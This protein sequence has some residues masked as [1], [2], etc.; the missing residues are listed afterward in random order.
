MRDGYRW[1]WWMNAMNVEKKRR[2]ECAEKQ[3]ENCHIFSLISFISTS[4]RFCFIFFHTLFFLLFSSATAEAMPVLQ[5]LKRAASW[6]IMFTAKY[7]TCLLGYTPQ[8]C[9][10]LRT[11][12]RVFV[13]LPM[14]DDVDARWKMCVCMHCFRISNQTP[15]IKAKSREKLW[16]WLTLLH[17]LG[18]FSIIFFFEAAH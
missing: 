5:L 10:Q 16:L 13:D 3:I 8:R 14:N 2:N 4:L 12:I 6:H 1:V 15:H 9:W 11:R 17:W 7:I 18:F